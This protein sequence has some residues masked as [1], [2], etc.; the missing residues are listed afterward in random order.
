[1]KNMVDK[2]GSEASLTVTGPEFLEYEP[3]R[4]AQLRLREKCEQSDGR[5]NFLMLVEHPPVI[6]LGRSADPEE[7]LASEGELRDKGVEVA[8]VARG[9][10][11]TFHGPGQLVCYPILDLTRLG[12]DLHRYLWELEDWLI[13]LCE[14]YNIGTRR[15]EDRTGVWVGERKIAA[16]GVAARKWCSYHGVALNVSTDLSYF[17]LIVPCGFGDSGVTSVGREVEEAPDL[18]QVADRAVSG[19]CR[20]FGFNRVERRQ[21]VRAI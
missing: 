15:I 11:V 17:D 3:A 5:Q 1:M 2:S 20:H 14:S 10:R 8:E 18:E 7:V 12:R 6:T 19:F 9:G 4:Q 21:S 16:I 13:Q